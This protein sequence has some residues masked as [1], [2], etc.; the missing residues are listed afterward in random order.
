MQPTARCRPVRPSDVALWTDAV[1]TTGDPHDACEGGVDP[2]VAGKIALI[3][4]GSCTFVS[5]SDAAAEA[6]SAI[7]R[8]DLQQHP[9]RWSPFLAWRRLGR[10]VHDPL[11]GHLRTG[12]WGGYGGRAPGC[13]RHTPVPI[14]TESSTKW[15]AAAISGWCLAYGTSMASPAAA[16]VAALIKARQSRGSPLGA[17]QGQAA[18]D[19]GRRGPERPRR[20]LRSRLRQRAPRLHRV[21]GA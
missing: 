8:D 14:A 16:G 10:S 7:G 19:R 11:G 17:P 2:G 18:P 3:H 6:S 9:R 1:D 4:R 20:V 15:R 12:R 5:K 13:Q 21:A